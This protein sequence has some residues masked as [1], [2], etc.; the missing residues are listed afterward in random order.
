MFK[1]I[2]IIYQIQFKNKIKKYNSIK[3]KIKLY[4][5]MFKK[6]MIINQI[7]YNN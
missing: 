7:K 2:M 5:I 3:I 1:R 4:K 6:I